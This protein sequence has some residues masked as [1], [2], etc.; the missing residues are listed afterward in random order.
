MYLAMFSIESGKVSFF[1]IEGGKCPRYRGF[2]VC[3]VGWDSWG[4]Y[5]PI[6]LVLVQVPTGTGTGN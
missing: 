4:F 2:S 3:G 5:L 6:P 1:K